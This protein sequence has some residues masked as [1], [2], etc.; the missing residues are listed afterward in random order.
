MSDSKTKRTS[1][2]LSPESREHLLSIQNEQVKLANM[3]QG[4]LGLLL[5]QNKLTGAYSLSKDCQTLDPVE[6]SNT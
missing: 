3:L 2:T 4:A 5:S 6:S 1:F